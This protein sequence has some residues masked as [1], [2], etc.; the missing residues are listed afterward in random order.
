MD[1][2][3]E[4]IRRASMAQEHINVVRNR[5]K[6]LMSAV[7]SEIK[8]LGN[9]RNKDW[10]Y[11]EQGAVI[12]TNSGVTIRLASDAFVI[13]AGAVYFIRNVL[14]PLESTSYLPCRFT[15]SKVDG[16]DTIY[17]EID[18]LPIEFLADID[19]QLVPVVEILVKAFPNIGELLD[20]LAYFQA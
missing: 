13:D 14:I 7:R 19:R 2:S 18:A 5:I 6:Q 1:I 17:R 11:P 12:A 9:I 3:V 10:R 16:S 8:S 4:S 20:K 15:I